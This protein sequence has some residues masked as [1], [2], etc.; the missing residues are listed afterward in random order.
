MELTLGDLP[1]G[2]VFL[3]PGRKGQDAGPWAAGPRLPSGKIVARHTRRLVYQIRL[4]PA[5]P[6]Q[7][8]PPGSPAGG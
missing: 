3:L 1:P 6:V 7:L 4:A 8:P 2:Q 5:T